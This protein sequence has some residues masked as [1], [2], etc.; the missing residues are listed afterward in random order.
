MFGRKAYLENVVDILKFFL[1]SAI[2]DCSC[3]PA[4]VVIVKSDSSEGN[5]YGWHGHCTV[6]G[7]DGGTARLRNDAAVRWVMQ[8]RAAMVKMTGAE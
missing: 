8:T 5:Q 2:L 3:G 6:C 7:K 1:K 4:R